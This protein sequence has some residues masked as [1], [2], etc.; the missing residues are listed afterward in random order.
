MQISPDSPSPPQS[1]KE[2]IIA[3]FLKGVTEV[4][5]IARLTGARPTYIGSLLQKEGLIKGY[6]DLYTSSQFF[7]NAYSKNFANRLGFKDSLS[8]QKSLRVLTRNYNK[9]KK[10]GDRA[11]QHHTLIMALTMFNRARWMGKN[12]EAKAFSQWLIEHLS[13]EK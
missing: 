6:F 12:Q 13:L 2:Q 1:K 3:L 8:V 10:S 9:F 7:M 5:E 4:D 11:G